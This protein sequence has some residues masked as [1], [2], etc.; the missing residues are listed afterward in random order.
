MGRGP[1]VG[2]ARVDEVTHGPSQ[3]KIL[4]ICH[5]E[6]IHLPELLALFEEPQ[7]DG[8]KAT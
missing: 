7:V 3:I 5:H 6:Q 4:H 2:E 1:A 8:K